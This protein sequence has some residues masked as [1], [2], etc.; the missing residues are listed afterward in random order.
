MYSYIRM[1]Q[2]C[3]YNARIADTATCQ[4]NIRISE[5]ES[6]FDGLICK[7]PIDPKL[8]NNMQMKKQCSCVIIKSLK[9]DTRTFYIQRLNQEELKQS[10]VYHY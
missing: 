3:Q 4:M 8:I 5:R 7:E 2:I 6:I 10:T 1:N 9:M